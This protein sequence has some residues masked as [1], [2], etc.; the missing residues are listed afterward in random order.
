MPSPRAEHVHVI[1]SSSTGIV[2]LPGVLSEHMSSVFIL[3]L[4]VSALSWCR[5]TSE[6]GWALAAKS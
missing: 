6:R 3:V 4:D 1:S 5:R 2:Q